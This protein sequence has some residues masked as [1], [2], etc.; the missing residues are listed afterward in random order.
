MKIILPLLLLIL[1]ACAGQRS[2]LAR[3]ATP[4]LNRQTLLHCLGM[5]SQQERVGN[6][7]ILTYNSTITDA[8]CPLKA[9]AGME[10]PL[11][12][13]QAVFTLEGDRVRTINYHQQDAIATAGPNLCAFILEDCGK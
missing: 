8:I 11:H 13:C 1:T 12:H 3:S 2:E 9:M 4:N 7:E 6:Q 10:P 5:P